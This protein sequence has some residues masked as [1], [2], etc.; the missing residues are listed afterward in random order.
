MRANVFP[1]ILVYACSP[2]PTLLQYTSSMRA[3]ASLCPHDGVYMGVI[4][5][6]PGL[7]F[8][9]HHR[10]PTA[11]AGQC[12]PPHF[13]IRMFPAAN[14]API[15]LFDASL[16]VAMPTRRCLHGRDSPGTR[17]SVL[18]SSPRPHGACGPM[19]SPTFWYTHVPRSQHCSNTPLRCEPTR[20]YAHTTVSTWA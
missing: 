17:A 14:I 6:A 18:G 20:R 9:A 12:F 10:A 5:P 16:R 7:R 13:G 19:F 4:A 15:H 2:P 8:S 3:Y 11:R 1:H